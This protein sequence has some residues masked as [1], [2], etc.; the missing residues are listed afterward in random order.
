MEMNYKVMSW[1]VVLSVVSCVTA[2]GLDQFV[3]AYLKRIQSKDRLKVRAVCLLIPFALFAW[4]ALV[5]QF[6]AH[7]NRHVYGKDALICEDA[8]VRLPNGYGIAMCDTTDYGGVHNL[9]INPKGYIDSVMNVRTLQIE[10]V[11]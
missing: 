6:Q 2:V 4:T 1:V 11:K 7:I 9:Q 10:T 5:F 8:R 3:I